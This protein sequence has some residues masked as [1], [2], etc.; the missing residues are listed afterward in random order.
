MNN[1]NII[2]KHKIFNLIKVPKTCKKHLSNKIDS[3][4]AVRL[5]ISCATDSEVKLLKRNIYSE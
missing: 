5:A 3:V 2:D 4:N 1:E